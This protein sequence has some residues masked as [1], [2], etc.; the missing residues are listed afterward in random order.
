MIPNS[1]LKT[2]KTKG[3]PNGIK[4]KQHFSPFD[5]FVGMASS[6]LTCSKLQ[7]TDDLTLLQTAVSQNNINIVV[8]LRNRYEDYL[9]QIL[10][11]FN[12]SGMK[13]ENTISTKRDLL[14]T[15]LLP[16]DIPTNLVPIKTTGDGNCLFNSL[17]LLLT[18]KENLNG[19]LRLLAAAEIFFEQRISCKP[20][21][22]CINMVTH[23][24]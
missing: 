20:S 3:I 24:V 6:K 11:K 1:V 16:R 22:V 5:T 12:G 2:F 7:L 10:V 15:A 8:Y 14:S 23:L 4:Y 18:S 21:K 17:S 19:I 13:Y 9:T